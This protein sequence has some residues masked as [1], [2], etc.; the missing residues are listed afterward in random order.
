MPFDPISAGLAGAGM[1][2]DLFKDAGRAAEA[3]RNAAYQREAIARAAAAAQEGRAE[4]MRTAGSLRQDQFGNAT[5]WDPAQGRWVTYYTPTQRAL[6]EGGEQRQRRAQTRG[7]QASQ[8][9]DTLRGEYLYNRP[10]SEA[11]SYAE[12]ARLISQARGTEEQQ[13]NQLMNRWGVRTAGNLPELVPSKGAQNPLADLAE[14]MLRARQA[15]LEEYGT[16]EKLHQGRYLPAMKQFEE[17]ANYVAPID[18]TGSEITKMTQQG[19]SDM[20]KTGTAY[21]QLI[22][23]ILS[24]GAATGGTGSAGGGGTNFANTLGNIGKLLSSASDKT[25]GGTLGGT[26]GARTST[27]GGDDG[28]VKLD[29]RF[30]YGLWGK[31]LGSDVQGGEAAPRGLLGEGAMRFGEGGFNDPNQITGFDPRFGDT[32]T[33]NRPPV[34]DWSSPYSAGSGTSPWGSYDTGFGNLWQF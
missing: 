21:D 3:R 26:R 27:S 29:N 15:A 8:D 1:V 18:P 20:L 17:T 32:F 9:Y 33:Y 7:A 12:I 19:L 14:T 23:Q 30:N 2:L 31:G 24:R 13:L 6:I 11:E 28:G 34:Y 25:A 5:Y 10:K 4:S 16:R 22:G